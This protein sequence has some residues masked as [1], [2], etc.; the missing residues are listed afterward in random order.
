MSEHII[1]FAKVL[2]WGTCY[3]F[4]SSVR[5]GHEQPVEGYVQTVDDREDFSEYIHLI[6]VYQ[7]GI[8]CKHFNDTIK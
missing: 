5:Q 3:L 4:L 1:I 7:M 6:V 8:G 2:L